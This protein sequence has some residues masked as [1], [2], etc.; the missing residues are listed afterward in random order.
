M[1][2]DA[3]S[4]AFI[5]LAQKINIPNF[6]GGLKSANLTTDNPFLNAGA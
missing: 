4:D 6:L 1:Q 5:T 2:V 3:S